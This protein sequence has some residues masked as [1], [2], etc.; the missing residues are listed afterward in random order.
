MRR[1]RDRPYA[2]T[3]HVASRLAA[4]IETAREGI[5]E[6]HAVAENS[7]AAR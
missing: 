7:F 3:E 4:T 6:P 2:A 5:R 1:D